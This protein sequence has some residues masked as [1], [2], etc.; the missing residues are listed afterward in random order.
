MSS[1]KRNKLKRKNNIARLHH[2]GCLYRLYF[3]V[4][5]GMKK[6]NLTKKREGDTYST[7]WKLS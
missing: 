1:K 4:M 2:I 5:G 7:I 3:L 6:Q